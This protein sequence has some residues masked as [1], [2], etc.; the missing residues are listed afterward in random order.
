MGRA[1]RSAIGT[2]VVLTLTAALAAC[3]DETGATPPSP[4]PSTPSSSASPGPQTIR[5]SVYGDDAAVGAYRAI[6]DSFEADHPEV[7]IVIRQHSD[8]AA[9]AED[10]IA[11]LSAG[12]ATASPSGD[13]DSSSPAPSTSPTSKALTPPDVFLLDQ[14]YLPDLVSTGRLHPLDEELEERGVEF[15]DDYQR[16]AL[17]AFSADSALQCMPFEMSPTVLFVN[18]RLVRYPR[19]EAEGI[20]PP[21]EQGS[22]RWDDFADTAR[23]VAR[24]GLHA[25]YLPA[26]ADLLNALMSSA[27][28]DIVDDFAHP[29]KLD[30]DSGAGRE[31]LTAY[32]ELARDRSVTLPA[33]QAQRVDPLQRFVDGRLAFLFGTRADVPTLRASG[34][35]FDALSIPGFGR[36]RASTAI[37]GLCVDADSEVRDT[38]VDFVAH[39]VSEESLTEAA[40]TGALVPASLDVVNSPEFEQP[41]R[42][43][44]TV[45]PF[46]EGQK[47][48]VLMPYSL[49]WRQAETR[50]QELVAQLLAGTSRD[51]EEELDTELPAIDEESKQWFEQADG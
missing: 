27:G 1:A 18:K 39:A 11:D 31:V 14:H 3:T 50:V 12:G 4:S 38:A 32:A 28:G 36:G 7:R 33:R 17:T 49:G 15:G 5:F 48:S 43:P 20:D 26:D 8:A 29:S 40:R 45:E 47:R 16:I 19:L 6:A 2:A 23:L 13:A 10:A 34:T 46:L 51:I 22:W 21:G 41:N 44:R 37:S 25:V 35:R 9:A 30:L 24:P 42:R